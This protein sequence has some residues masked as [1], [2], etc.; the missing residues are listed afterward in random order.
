MI[1][2]HG[3]GHFHPENV[4]DNLFLEHL[5]IGCD[6]NWTLER[7]GIE[8]RRTVLPLEYIRETKNQNP[9]AAHEASIYTNAQTGA[10]AALMA[11]QRAGISANEIGLVISGSCSPQYS[12]P[13]EACTIAAAL[14]IE[15]PAFDVNSAC[16]SVLAHLN[17]LESTKENKLPDYVLVVSPENNT[18]V[19]DYTD[20]STAVLWGDCTSAMVVSTKVPSKVSISD[21]FLESSPAGWDKVRIP[22]AGLFRQSGKTVQKYAIKKSLSVI[23]QI[24]EGMS[25]EKNGSLKYIGHQANLTMLQSVC[26]LAEIPSANH[27]YNVD[28]FGNGGAAGVVSVLSQNW[29]ELKSGDHIVLAIVG[30]GLTW[31]GALLEVRDEV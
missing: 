26:R 21:P 10:K 27:L 7:V 16:S 20:R 18:R 4:I 19:V 29:N 13:A 17:Y 22:P 14:E 2:V 12:V 23:K 5:D 1:Y 6:T 9:R 31:G 25:S 15:A 28:E 30:A 24:R 3:V 11:L 8:T